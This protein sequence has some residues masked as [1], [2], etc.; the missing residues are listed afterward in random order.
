[1]KR[2]L[3]PETLIISNTFSIPGWE[4]VDVRP[5]QDLFHSPVYLY[6]TREVL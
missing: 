3:Q 2:E 6:K 5:A 1:M 4:P